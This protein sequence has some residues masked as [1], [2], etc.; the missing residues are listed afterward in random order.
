KPG[1][2]CRRCAPGNDR[3]HPEPE[4]FL[5]DAH[6]SLGGPLGPTIF[7][8]QVLSLDVAKLAK[9]L[10]QTL[11]C[12]EREGRNYSDRHLP[13]CRCVASD[14]GHVPERPAR[15]RAAQ[16]RDELAPLHVWMAPA[17]QEKM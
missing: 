14:V 13:R 2:H 12:R 3:V 10:A 9:T 11:D 6:I 4:Q 15:Y 16:Q 8:P 7:E 17:W 1:P 5:R